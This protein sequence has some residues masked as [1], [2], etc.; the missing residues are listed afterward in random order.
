MPGS[1]TCLRWNM[2]RSSTSSCPSLRRLGWPLPLGGTSNVFARAALSDCGAW[3]PYNVTE[4]ADLGFRL[5]RHG[6][7]AGIIAPGTLEEAPVRLKAWTA[8][9]SRWLK[10]HAIS[11]AVQ[12]RE[13]GALRREAGLGGFAGI[14]GKPWRE[15]RS[16]AHRACACPCSDCRTL[17]RQ[18]WCPPPPPPCADPGACGLWR[19]DAGGVDRRK[20]GRVFAASARSD[21][22]ARL[23]VAAVSGH[24]T[25]LARDRRGAPY[26]W[27]EDRSPP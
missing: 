17:D 20:T 23:L 1:H 19:S 8:Q 10:G 11:W 26:F 25:G 7:Q 22:P 3:D 5:A 12:M 9:R 14:A 27:G 16:R 2:P 4:D 18:P 15:P 13:P 21:G 24:D 6:W